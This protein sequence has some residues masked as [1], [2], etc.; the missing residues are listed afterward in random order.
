MAMWRWG[1]IVVL[2]FTAGFFETLQV[3]RERRESPQ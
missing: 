2:L 3:I 1:L